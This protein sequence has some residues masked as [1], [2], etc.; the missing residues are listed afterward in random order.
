[1]S[2]SGHTQIFDRVMFTS[3]TLPPADSAP[4]V[5][6]ATTARALPAVAR[7]VSLYSGM[8]SQVDMNDMRADTVLPRPTLLDQPDPNMARSLFVTLQME[9]YLLNGNALSLVTGRDA[10]GWPSSVAWLPAAWVSVTLT[11]KPY[12][13]DVAYWA[14]GR[15]LDRGAIVHVRRGADRWCPAR[16][17][18]VVEGHLST[19][20][21]VATE[22][23]YERDNLQ[24]GS[25]PS[26]AIITP[27][28]RLSGEE[29]G[30]A[31]GEWLAKFIR[32]EPAFFPAG[33]QVIPLAWSPADS[34]LNA[35]RQM[36]LLD[37]ANI[38]NLDGYWLGA[39]AGSF[40][41]RSPGQMYTA[42][43]RVSLE[44][45]MKPFEDVWSEAWLPR[46][47]RV[48]F[49]RLALTRDDIQTMVQTMSMAVSSNLMSREEARVYMG[50]PVVQAGPETPPVP[51][52][53]S[54]P[55]STDPQSEVE[56]P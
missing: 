49:D 4:M 33:T 11:G 3:T 36:S 21:R 15:Q 16:G 48:R 9:D 22:E 27:N 54:P 31:K 41:Y 32:R 25:V 17:V 46:G 13:D 24:S 52:P 8:I 2:G 55:T 34:E 50:L 40:T 53:A 10:A 23:R 18:G 1:M 39:P 5:W 44:P 28:P 6:D 37:V 47:R 51:Q 26:V 35:A 56:T 29:A 30:T 20:E 45:V 43:L 38:F 14:G 12:P 7:A 42:M 19:L